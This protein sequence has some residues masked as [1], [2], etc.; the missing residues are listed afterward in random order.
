MSI[1]QLALRFLGFRF[2]LI[3]LH[4]LYQQLTLPAGTM[5]FE[6]ICMLAVQGRSCCCNLIGE[7]VYSG[8]R[9]LPFT[10][11]GNPVNRIRRRG[12][13]REERNAAPV[14]CLGQFQRVS[15]RP[16]LFCCQ[17]QSRALL[18]FSQ[19]TQVEQPIETK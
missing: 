3:V 1:V 16:E 19:N 15:K 2:F 12:S 14:L 18:F 10:E 5:R 6:Q 8:R 9:D 4:C 7:L 11:S 13:C 17:M